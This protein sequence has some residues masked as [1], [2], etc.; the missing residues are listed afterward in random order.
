MLV[1]EAVKFGVTLAPGSYYRPNG[2]AC[3]WVRINSAYAGDRRATRF[4]EFMTE[5]AAARV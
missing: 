3:P 2:E 1:E 5:A 4:F